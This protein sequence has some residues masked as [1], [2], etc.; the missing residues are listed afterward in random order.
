MEIFCVVLGSILAILGQVLFNI[1][2]NGKVQKHNTAMIYYDIQSILKY[3]KQYKSDKQD[4]VP[5]IRYHSE[6]QNM[7]LELNYLKSSQVLCIYDFYDAVYD[8]DCAMEKGCGIEFF[9]ELEKV[10]ER[11]DFKQV[12]KE[13]EHIAKIRRG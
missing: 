9:E 5:N 13:F 8:Y 12:I 1:F 11:E 10:A 4:V 6:W 7:L 3:V 2:N